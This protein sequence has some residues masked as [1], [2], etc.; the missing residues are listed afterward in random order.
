MSLD[1]P[2]LE[3]QVKLNGDLFGALNP[4]PVT[5]DEVQRDNVLQIPVWYI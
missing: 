2:F 5:I 3:E 4:A 1:N